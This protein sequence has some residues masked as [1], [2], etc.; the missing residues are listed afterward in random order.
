MM[1][2]T[3]FMPTDY[4]ISL[5]RPAREGN[6]VVRLARTPLARASVSIVVA[7]VAALGG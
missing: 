5:G 4:S 2:G 7:A 6:M 1:F 3:S